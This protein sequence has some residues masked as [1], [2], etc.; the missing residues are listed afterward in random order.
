MR[1]AARCYFQSEIG[2]ARFDDGA[3]RGRIDSA[4]GLVSW[5]ITGESVPYDDGGGRFG[6]VKPKN[7]FGAWELALRYDTIRGRQN[8]YGAADLRDISMEATTA[9]AN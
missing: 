3:Q 6:R 4:Y 9:G 2:D 8:R 7:S 5:F 1:C